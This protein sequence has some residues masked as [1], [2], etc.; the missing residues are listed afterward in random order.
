MASNIYQEILAKAMKTAPGETGRKNLLITEALEQKKAALAGTIALRR[1]DGEDLT[2]EEMKAAEDSASDYVDAVIAGMVTMDLD[3]L[4]KL[5]KRTKSKKL[6]DGKVTGTLRRKTAM[7]NVSVWISPMDLRVILNAVLFRYTQDLMGT[8]GRLKN[9]TGRLAH[10]G[11][12]S[13]IEDS[14]GKK[15]VGKV[16]LYFKYMLEP[17]GTFE[18][19]KKMGSEARSPIALFKAA[20]NNALSDILTPESH[21]RV[22]IYWRK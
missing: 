20:L 18:P 12:V 15:S 7:N 21:K 8:A 2:A 9:R 6:V 3:K 1:A 10:S 11:F 19:G 16:S 4:I 13:R 17:Y 22:S 14:K 5:D